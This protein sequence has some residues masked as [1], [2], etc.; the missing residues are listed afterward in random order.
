MKAVTVVE[1][2]LA[3]KVFKLYFFDEHGNN[4]LN[5]PVRRHKLLAGKLPPKKTRRYEAGR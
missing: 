4:I 2:D 1:V 5:K 3:K